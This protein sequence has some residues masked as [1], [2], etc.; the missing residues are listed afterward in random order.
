MAGFVLSGSGITVFVLGNVGLGWG[1]WG[2]VQ[3]NDGE[4]GGVVG[5]GC[6]EGQ[7]WWC[8]LSIRGA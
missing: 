5:T 7:G 4:G 8:V 2:K 3:V 6:G 1:R